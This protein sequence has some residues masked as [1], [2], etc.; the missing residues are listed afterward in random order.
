M[1]APTHPASGDGS[2]FQPFSCPECGEMVGAI[3]L[4]SQ[5]VTLENATALTTRP[6]GT[7]ALPETGMED[8][9]EKALDL[10]C[11]ACGKEFMLG[12]DTGE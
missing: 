8:G 12:V 2:P 9:P 11:D 10:R 7:P 1:D 6:D 3:N 5:D 4:L